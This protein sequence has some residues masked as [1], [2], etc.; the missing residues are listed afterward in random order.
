[1]SKRGSNQ[2]KKIHHMLYQHLKAQKQMAEAQGSRRFLSLV[3][4]SLC[5][6]FEVSKM[7]QEEKSSWLNSQESKE[8][9][10]PENVPDIEDFLS[11]RLQFLFFASSVYTYSVSPL[12]PYT[13]FCSASSFFAFSLYPAAIPSHCRSTPGLTHISRVLSTCLHQ[14]PCQCSSAFTIRFF[15]AMNF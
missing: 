13:V 10:D 11:A 9:A 12:L 5:L 8:G 1:M 15:P 6:K 4:E 7:A 14:G 3:L 2:G